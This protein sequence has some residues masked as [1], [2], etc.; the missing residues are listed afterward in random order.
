MRR[1]SSLAAAIAA[2]LAMCPVVAEAGGHGGGHGGGVVIINGRPAGPV[3]TGTPSALLLDLVPASAQAEQGLLS[4]GVVVGERTLRAREAVVLTADVKHEGIEIAAGT[5]MVRAAMIASAPGSDQTPPIYCAV[6][7]LAVFHSAQEDCLQDSERKG[8]LD[9]FWSGYLYDHNAP[10]SL[11]GLSRGT[12]I[13]PVGFRPASA[14]ELPTTT[15]GYRFCGGQGDGVD[16][17]YRFTTVMRTAPDGWTAYLGACPFGQWPQASDKS[18]EAVDS[19]TLKLSPGAPPTYAVVQ[20]LQGGPLAPVRIGEA[21]AA[22]GTP[23]REVLNKLETAFSAPLVTRG[24]V[25][26]IASGRIEHGATLALVPVA[27]GVTGVLRNDVQTR[28]PFFG[29][30]RLKAGQYM[31][32]IP[33]RS[34]SAFG[35]QADSITWCAPQVVEGPPANISTLCFPVVGSGVTAQNEGAVL[36][37]TRLMFHPG[38]VSV[39]G[40]SVERRPAEFERPM[41][42]AYVFDRWIAQKLSGGKQVM[43]ASIGVEIRSGDLVTPID[44]VLVGPGNDRIYRFPLQGGIITLAPTGK[45]GRALDPPAVVMDTPQIDAF[46]DALDK[47]HVLVAEPSAPTGTGA[48]PLA[49]IVGLQPKGVTAPPPLPLSPSPASSQPTAPAAP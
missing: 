34:T 43:L 3:Y 8:V 45:D 41:T 36:M 40:L 38:G 5:V 9:A 19:I 13:E 24:A 15:V 1:V 7:A 26:D 20:G 47:T 16:I 37:V 28:L 29:G 48:L 35:R 39:I 44:H 49:G 22:Q 46:F 4:P 30:D 31:F 6:K 11:M 14:D 2:A 18:V 25:H 27:H 32:G 23:S 12:R 21:L 17:P 10:F 42:L 33:M